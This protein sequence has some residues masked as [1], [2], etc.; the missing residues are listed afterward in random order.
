MHIH[1]SLLGELGETYVALLLKRFNVQS[2]L[3]GS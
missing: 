1:I 3:A 2:C